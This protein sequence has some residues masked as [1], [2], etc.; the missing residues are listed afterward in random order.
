MHPMPP[1]EFRGNLVSTEPLRPAAEQYHRVPDALTL[2]PSN[3][4][5][6]VLHS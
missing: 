4:I 5:G 2:A 3:V 6:T 1:V